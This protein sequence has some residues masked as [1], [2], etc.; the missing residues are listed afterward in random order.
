MKRHEN[1]LR[2]VEMVQSLVRE[3]YEEGR[4]DRCLAAVWRVWVY[5]K[6]PMC[7]ETL[8]RIMSIDLPQ[9]QERMR[10]AQ[11]RPVYVEPTLFGNM[12]F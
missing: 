7:Y 8:R 9:E 1:Y 4:Q 2:Y 11:S 12:D 10:V 5:P 3:H 6:Y